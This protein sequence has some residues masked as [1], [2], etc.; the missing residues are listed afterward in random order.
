MPG[1]ARGARADREGA[2]RRRHPRHHDARGGRLRGPPTDPLASGDPTAAGDLPHREVDA[3]GH[4]EGPRD[5]RQLLHHEAVQRSRPGTQGPYLPGGA[6]RHAR[7]P[8]P[9]GPMTLR[10]AALLLLA[11]LVSPPPARAEW[12]SAGGSE[13]PLDGNGTSWLVHATLNGRLTGL[14]L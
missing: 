5:G 8:A 12:T 9:A 2:A 10:I 4:R 1:R 7:R 11:A 6:A 13:V 14:F 3:G